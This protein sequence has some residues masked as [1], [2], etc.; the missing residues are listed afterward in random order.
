MD[1]HPQPLIPPQH[2][3][4]PPH[5]LFARM[6]TAVVVVLL[7][8]SDVTSSELVKIEAEAMFKRARRRR[9]E[10]DC[11]GYCMMNWYYALI[12]TP[13]HFY[14]F[15]APGCLHCGTARGA[16]KIF[17]H[18]QRELIETTLE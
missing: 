9:R 3:P 6:A 15:T 16:I 17:A 13:H 12:I 4:I 14:R 2:P 11:F 7:V 18:W 1:P 8:T 5:C 10:K